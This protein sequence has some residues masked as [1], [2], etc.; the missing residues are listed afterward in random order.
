M[1]DVQTE[2]HTLLTVAQMIDQA[3][4][5]I[6]SHIPLATHAITEH[7]LMIAVE[8]LEQLRSAIFVRFGYKEPGKLC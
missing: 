5:G 2:Q 1:T 6:Q 8:T 7:H 4:E 3:A